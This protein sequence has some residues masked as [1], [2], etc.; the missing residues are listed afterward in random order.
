[1]GPTDQKDGTVPY[2]G[3][4]S[5]IAMDPAFP[6]VIYAA[7][8]TQGIFK[9]IDG[10][11]NWANITDQ[12]DIPAIGISQMALHP[13]NPDILY[14]TTG[15]KSNIYGGYSLGVLKTV[16][17]GASWQII[18]NLGEDI[19]FANDYNDITLHGLLI[20]PNTPDKV[21]VGGKGKIYRSV[22]NGSDWEVFLLPGMEDSYICDIAYDAN[23]NNVIYASTLNTA[24]NGLGN[25]WVSEDGG[26]SW[27]IKNPNAVSNLVTRLDN[28]NADPTRI[29]CSL[30][31]SNG[32]IS[33]YNSSDHGD[34][35]NLVYDSFSNNGYG[36]Y[37]NAFEVSNISA[38]LIYFG[39]IS[40][41]IGRRSNGVWSSE[42]Q[43]SGMHDD[44]RDIDLYSF[45][46]GEEYLLVSS[47]GGVQQTSFNADNLIAD[48]FNIAWNE[49]N[50]VG[51]NIT[52]IYG[53]GVWD[54]RPISMYG[55]QDIGTWVINDGVADHA[56][57]ADGGFASINEYF[58]T[59]GIGGD[60]GTKKFTKDNGTNFSNVSTNY[61]MALGSGTGTLVL[62][63]HFSSKDQREVFVADKDLA[64]WTIDETTLNLNTN[65]DVIQFQIPGNNNN[66]LSASAL[67]IAPSDKNTMY[68]AFN[69]I[70]WINDVTD[71]IDPNVINSNGDLINRVFKTVD[72]GASWTDISNDFKF[73]NQNN[74]VVYPYQWSFINYLL[75]DPN[76]PN[77]LYASLGTYASEPGYMRILLSENGGL[78][79]A[80]YSDGFGSFPVR[81]I[82]YHDGVNEVL[83]AATDGGVYRREGD[84]GSWECFNNG[85][86]P[87]IVTSMD[88]D[89]CENSMQIATYGR[90]IWK[91][92][93]PVYA[94]D[95]IISSNT[96]IAPFE[97]HTLPNNLIVESGA[98][99]T[100]EGRLLFRS[101]KG[102]FVKTGA[103][104]IV[105]G[106]VLSNACPGQLW[107]GIVVEGDTTLAQMPESNQG[108]CEL[109][110]DALIENAH[111]GVHL[112]GLID[113]GNGICTYDEGKAG[114]VLR[115]FDAT[116]KNC[117]VGAE[118]F[119][120][121][122]F[123][124]V[125]SPRTNRSLFARCQ[126]ITDKI[127]DDSPI[128][129]Q[130]E[131]K[132]GIIF[133][134]V[135]RVKVMGCTFKNFA[136]GDPEFASYY[137]SQYKRGDGIQA[138]SAVFLLYNSVS[139]DG[140]NT[141]IVSQFENLEHGIKSLCGDYIKPFSCKN[142]VFTNNF[143]GIRSEGSL[144]GPDIRYNTF[145]V[146]PIADN[147]DGEEVSGIDMDNTTKFNIS[148]NVFVGTDIAN[149]QTTVGIAFNNTALDCGG[150]ELE[151]FMNAHNIVYRNKMDILD[152]GINVQGNNAIPDP[153]NP[154]E[155]YGLEFRCNK[156]GQNSAPCFTDFNLFAGSTVQ[157]VQGALS[158][159]N[160]EAA[161]IFDNNVCNNPVEHFTVGAGATVIDK[162]YHNPNSGALTLEP[163]CYNTGSL[164]AHDTQ[165]DYVETQTCP[166][167]QSGVISVGQVGNKLTV[168]MASYEDTHD[169]YYNQ[170]DN[171]DFQLL[172][173]LVDNPN[174][175]SIAIRNELIQC[176][177]FVSD[178]I[179]RK[180][181][182]RQPAMNPWHLAQALLHNSP[183]KKTVLQMVMA[184]DLSP[185]YKTL[186]NNGQTGGITTRDVYESDLA[187]LNRQIQECRRDLVSY[188]LVDEDDDE[189]NRIALSSTFLNSA[190][191][192]DR[193][194]LAS[195]S[196][197][198]GDYTTMAQTLNGCPAVNGQSDNRCQLLSAIAAD[199]QDGN[200]ALSPATIATL[201]LLAQDE[202]ECGYTQARAW[203]HE[204][205]DVEFAQNIETVSLAYRSAS[206]ETPDLITLPI[207]S[208]Q[209]NPSKGLVYITYQL[210]EGIES[211]DMEILDSNGQLMENR[212]INSKG[213]E[214]WNCK[215]C[216][217]GI[218][219]VRLMAGGIELGV[220]KVSIVK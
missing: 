172:A 85:L 213:I 97:T 159:P 112:A 96:S 4:I 179:W 8:N 175:E 25:I 27:V 218:Y 74:Q 191:A 78:D 171:G 84:A 46:N 169:I 214:E 47:D 170:I 82:L 79:W 145:Y 115:A 76:D 68:I 17:G 148:E 174:S 206:V 137:N 125:N 124:S 193:L 116:F 5:S 186:V 28:T 40:F 202:T 195:L 168:K 13:N 111:T 92:N 65:P 49:L 184:S 107:Q 167:T 165:S 44:I 80:D 156:F 16:N 45:A 141:P 86:P 127:L 118:F 150:D 54:R 181:I 201:H 69:G 61:D 42:T 81:Q 200:P 101:G 163:N 157:V 64:K 32:L 133:N 91:I 183:L 140:L 220:S 142:A 129:Q 219:L 51:L 39:G 134:E 60:Q 50:G 146:N 83:Y 108:Y 62:R 182:Q 209:P 31:N 210:P 105:D 26:N 217:S 33:V 10:G 212:N 208:A 35:W 12:L 177:P 66:L 162:Y 73:T 138:N 2:Q 205:N 215:E 204:Y 180:A 164:I 48:Q 75:V 98:T 211:C 87:C 114:G 161:N 151:D 19:N 63:H 29:Y 155:V 90:G 52:Q 154:S 15:T 56:L 102:L 11:M 147:M 123:T 176:S 3:L 30:K 103:K 59:F 173:A 53:L 185:Y 72:G 37:K 122:F 158:P 94:G 55:A 70:Y 197:W 132:A 9:T 144:L 22:N 23:D 34:S 153:L 143:C 117:Y 119:P 7:G 188:Y 192:N 198:K 106:G 99:L 149:L 57:G 6:D 88:I 160:E 110:N 216:P 100:V 187:L 128:V 89:Y 131:P 207:L 58:D 196:A 189:V 71:L 41:S 43:H 93:L 36:F 67:A 24:V 194:I 21:F 120:Y 126:F 203:L 113:L 199:R 139:T 18:D 178:I 20:H 135:Y 14:A 104:L 130:P 109:K 77:R 190:S 1:M 136:I 38:D 166:V 121:T 152:V 95:Q